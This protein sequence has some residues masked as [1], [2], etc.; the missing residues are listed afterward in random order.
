[1]KYKKREGAPL[2]PDNVY[3][4]TPFETGPSL[5]TVVAGRATIKC[6]RTNC[7]TSGLSGCVP[8]DGECAGSTALFQFR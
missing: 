7:D 2:F 3:S 1:M 8:L 6:S 4:L 5:R